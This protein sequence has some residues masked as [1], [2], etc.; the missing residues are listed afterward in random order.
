MR[1]A[2]HGADGQTG[3]EITTTVEAPDELS[4]ER[5]ARYQYQDLLISGISRLPE[6][7]EVALPPMSEAAARPTRSM[8]PAASVSGNGGHRA[9]S[10][11]RSTVPDYID[12]IAGA[13]LLRTLA[14]I[15]VSIGIV[16][17]FWAAVT[18]WLAMRQQ[19]DRLTAA[20]AG[21]RPG[22]AGLAMV[23]ASAVLRVGASVAMAVRDLV[24]NS[25][26]RQP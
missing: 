9:G 23:T 2:I 6:S 19:T 26:P 15:L 20:V 25:Y 18:V 5:V 24:R 21:F 7:D 11:R 13:G 17:L 10:S 4:A 12:I 1:W 3:K 14:V 22:L 16:C 8:A